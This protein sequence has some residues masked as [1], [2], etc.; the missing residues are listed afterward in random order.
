MLHYLLVLYP[1]Y[2][3]PTT[4]L[5]SPLNLLRASHVHRN[6]EPVSGLL[7]YQTL[8]FIYFLFFFIFLKEKEVINI[9]M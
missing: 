7:V 1:L 6:I 5:Y 2:L 4:S 3:K 8:S 9:K